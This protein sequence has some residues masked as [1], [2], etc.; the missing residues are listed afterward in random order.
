MFFGIP[1]IVIASDIGEVFDLEVLTW[2]LLH[3][4]LSLIATLVCKKLD[5]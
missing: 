3:T 4:K 2:L 5:F 1:T